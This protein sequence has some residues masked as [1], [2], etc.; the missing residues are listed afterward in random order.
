MFTVGVG[1]ANPILPNVLRFANRHPIIPVNVQS[2]R[3]AACIP[4]INRIVHFSNGVRR[5]WLRQP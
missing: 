3:P 4:G 2:R 5:G 1:C